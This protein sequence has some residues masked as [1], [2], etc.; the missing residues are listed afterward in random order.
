MTEDAFRIVVAV[1]V[2]LAALAFV[3]QACVVIAFYRGSKKTQHTITSV[4]A[5]AE[6]VIAKIEPVVDQ[7]APVLERIGLTIDRLGP[8]IDQLVP[9][10]QKAGPSLERI[11]PAADKVGQVVDKVGVVLSTANRILEDSRPRI[12]EISVETLAI[13]K[14]G[15]EQ[16]ERLGDLLHDASDRARHRLEQIDQTVE[17]TV[18]Q[19]EQV[20]DSVKRAVMKPVREVNGLAAGLSAA[21]STLVHGS[22]KSSVDSA[23]QDEEMFI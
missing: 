10:I 3:I 1:A 13:A 6:P 21:V 11:G 18:G 9:A 16:V 4:M 8:V 22:R 17:S 19:V 23:T 14:T 15:R 7:V 2:G 20:G 12:A 5:K